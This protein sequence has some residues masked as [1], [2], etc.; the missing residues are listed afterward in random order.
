MKLPFVSRSGRFDMDISLCEL[1]H[2]MSTNSISIWCLNMT[3]PEMTLL[4][5]GRNTILQVRI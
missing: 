4:S 2:M 5:D 1:V 3:N